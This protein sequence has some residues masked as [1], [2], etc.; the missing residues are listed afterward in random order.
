MQTRGTGARDA[1][2]RQRVD[3]R[4]GQ[5]VEAGEGG[6]VEGGQDERDQEPVGGGASTFD[7]AVPRDGV[8]FLRSTMSV[9]AKRSRPRRAGSGA[10][11]FRHARLVSTASAESA[12]ARFWLR[13][14]VAAPKAKTATP[15]PRRG[16][17]DSRRPGA[18][19]ASRE[20]GQR[21]APYRCQGI[22]EP[23]I[24]LF[25]LPLKRWSSASISQSCLA[26]GP[27]GRDRGGFVVGEA[28]L[29]AGPGTRPSERRRG[30]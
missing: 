6:V 24:Q 4:E 29:A 1:P 10:A 25:L 8:Q 15:P 17:R 14:T 21:P 7:V 9:T 26:R 16:P 30:A 2:A 11:P 23:L 20:A 27:S 5:Q 12:A 28:A 18:P 13:A 19:A 22:D 3:V